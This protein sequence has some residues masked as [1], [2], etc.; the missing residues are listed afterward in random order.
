MLAVIYSSSGGKTL[1]FNMGSGFPSTSTIPMSSLT[2]SIVGL[3]F[4]WNIPSGFGTVPSGDGGN[5]TSRG[6]NFP[7][8]STIFPGG[9][10]LGGKFPQWGGF[11]FIHTFGPGG[12]FLGTIF[13]NA[14]P[15]GSTPTPKGNPLRGTSIHGSNHV[16]RSATILGGTHSSGTP[17]PSDNTNVGG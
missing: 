4:G 5:N 17:H 13:V 8:V 3:A 9:T 15:L 14:F 1:G 16:P 2:L 11:P 7:W 6:F 12:F 10:S